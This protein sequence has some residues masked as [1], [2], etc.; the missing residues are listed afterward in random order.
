M[1]NRCV[2][3]VVGL[4]FGSEGK[5][6]LVERIAKDY[7]YHVRTGAPN[8]GHKVWDPDHTQQYAFQTI[9]CGAIVAPDAQLIIGRAAMIIEKQ[10]SKEIDWLEHMGTPVSD[11]LW[12]DPYAMIIEQR[13]INKE[14]SRDDGK[15]MSDRI[16]STREGC[17]AALADKV[18]RKDI[19]FAKDLIW[20][21]DY[22]VDTA[23]MLNTAIDNHEPILLEGTQGAGLSLHHTN[24]Y[25]FATSRDTNAANW[26]MEAG[27]APT[28]VRDVYGVARAFPIRV[29]GNSGPTGGKELT[30]SKITRMS[31]SPEKLSER[32]T[33]TNKIRRIFSWSWS[34]M[35]K[36]MMINR[37]TYICLNFTD[38]IDWNNFGVRSWDKIST[39]TIEV[40]K[41]IDERYCSD[42]GMVVRWIGTGPAYGHF[43]D[44]HGIH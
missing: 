36:A 38:Y 44:R 3:I 4:Q 39:P 28:V 8:A 23:V 10:L 5:G 35:D 16:G 40:I 32:T 13:H 2:D 1:T 41:E 27:L 19:K 9:P 6:R 20:L 42:D 37:P 25:P 33:V 14:H 26:L 30:W 17:G 24:W 15:D 7:K 18:W 29:G 43:I 34:D 12:I 11:R 21:K 31:G 22:I